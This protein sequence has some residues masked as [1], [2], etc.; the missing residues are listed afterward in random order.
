MKAATKPGEPVD[1]GGRRGRGGL[2]TGCAGLIAGLASSGC[3]AVLPGCGQGTPRTEFAEVAAELALADADAERR[4]VM[5]AQGAAL[6]ERLACVQC[7]R[8]DDELANAPTLAWTRPTVTGVRVVQTGPEAGER[9]EATVERD[10]AYVYTSITRPGSFLVR[11][12]ERAGS[13]SYF[14][15]LEAGDLASLMLHLE[16]E[17]AARGLKPVAVSE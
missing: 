14:G 4:A 2:P 7:H 3:V 15:F 5:V 17:R 9:T 12:Y 11:G 8:W 10:R 6:Y 16:A 13:M 1:R